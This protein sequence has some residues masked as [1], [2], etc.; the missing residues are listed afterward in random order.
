MLTFHFTGPKGQMTEPETLV[1]GMVGKQVRFTFSE[2]WEGLR[3]T[4]VYRAGLVSCTSQD[5][6][7]TDVI[8]ARV[9]AKALRRLYVGVYGTDEAGNVVIPTV[10]VPGP[11][12]HIGASEGT[13]I[14]PEDPGWEEFKQALAETV[15]FVPQTLSRK[16]QAQARA[17]IGAAAAAVE[18]AVGLGLVALLEK[19]VF[20]EDVSGELLALKAVLGSQEV[21]EIPEIPE[22]PGTVYYT[23]SCGL[24]NVTA[25]PTS[26]VVEQGRSCR[27]VLTAKDGYV[28]DTVTVTMG[29][30]D[31]TAAVWADGVV[32]IPAV[33]GN[34]V[35]TA[36]ALAA[37]EPGITYLAGSVYTVDG[38]SVINYQSVSNTDRICLLTTEKTAQEPFPVH[39]AGDGRE[40]YLI[41][42]PET[43]GKVEI[44]CPGFIGGPQFF[45]FRDGAYVQTK[46]GGWLGQDSC[47]LDIT[48]GAHPFVLVNF[49][50][51]D[52]SFFA[53]ADVDLSEFGIS[54]YDA[55]VSEP[56]EP[57]EPQTYSVTFSFTG[58]S[59]GNNQRTVTHGER[60]VNVLL[61]KADYVITSIK[62]T[63]GGQDVTA[64]AV[65]GNSII[66]DSITGP[67]SIT[68]VAE[69]EDPLRYLAASAYH[70]GTSTTINIMDAAST[71]RIS[72]V[73]MEPTADV[74]FPV[75]ANWTGADIY[76]LAVPETASVTKV[77]YPGFLCGLQY[78][79]LVDG[80][81]VRTIDTGW[82]AQNSC[83]YAITPG[84]NQYVALNFK[85]PD[86]SKFALA[87]VDF[88]GF[89]VE[90]E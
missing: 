9:L 63:M 23:L 86:N 5:I 89:A 36:K 7:E 79:N 48:P 10:F 26:A 90:F 84:E 4:A 31:I 71:D 56:E 46:D 77:T 28:L 25:Q 60:Y 12:I 29:G 80:A 39:G 40:W 32:A 54:F 17:N 37:E 73:T 76:L 18:K 57:E 22:E 42:V 11:F 59:A 51:P 82:Q 13:D 41:P 3:K 72:L 65:N 47:S 74:P 8:P 35:I 50:K 55:E 20:T 14:T 88:S 81:Y 61:P 1:S 6:G 44:T 15:R 58:V 45:A 24:Q 21:P 38:V 78:F 16:Q 68:A 49:K 34:V 70:N 62:V 83:D 19:A 43:A 66:I 67:V 69:K 2:E 33:T 52:A 30:K 64:T 27:V 75:S 85:K 53:M 87:D